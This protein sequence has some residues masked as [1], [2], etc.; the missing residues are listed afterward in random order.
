[1]KMSSLGWAAGFLE[2]EG[3]FHSGARISIRAAQVQP[4]PLYLMLSIL[5]GTVNGPYKRKNPN[6]HA[7]YDWGLNG[8]HA[9]AA[10][11]TIYPLMSPKRQLSIRQAIQKWKAAPGNA[12]LWLARGFCKNGHDLTG[13]NY[14]IAPSGHGRCRQCGIE[15][16]RRYYKKNSE[17]WLGYSRAARLRKTQGV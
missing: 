12:R 5:G 3:C 11:M 8:C 2:G 7:I 14:V 13:P 17:K 10:M 16:R 1:M 15:G 4:D 6:H 9:V